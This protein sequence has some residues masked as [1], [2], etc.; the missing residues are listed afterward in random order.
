MK[1][2]SL[3]TSLVFNTEKNILMQR[4]V[5]NEHEKN[6]VFPITESVYKIDEQ[7]N[8]IM[9]DE[10]YNSQL[11]DIAQGVVFRCHIL[12]SKQIS[13]NDLLTEDDLLGFNFHHALFDLLSF[14]IFLTDLNQAYTTTQLSNH[15]NTTLRYLDCKYQYVLYFSLILHQSSLSYYYLDSIIEQQMLM[16]SASIFWF[17]TLHHCNLDQPLSL[18]YDRYRLSNEH[19]SGR[20]ISISFNF[21]Q[22][23]SHHFLAYGSLKKIQLIHVALAIYYAFLFK[24]TNGESDLRIG[25]NTDGRYRDELK[26]MI[27]M[28]VNAIH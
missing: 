12:Y 20:G 25:M 3:R 11:F 24:L 21:S 6:S 28:F 18:Q 14:D 16:T 26:S 27:G 22:D 19:R 5:E 2:P 17:D 15:D 23:L 1:H 4:V 8:H 9:Y 10:Q 13:T 7:L